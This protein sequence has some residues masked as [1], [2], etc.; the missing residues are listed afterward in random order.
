MVGE[1]NGLPTPERTTIKKEYD[2]RMS[3]YKQV[4]NGR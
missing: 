2:L 3:D 1:V 4:S